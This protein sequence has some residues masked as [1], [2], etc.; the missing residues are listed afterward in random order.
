MCINGD[1]ITRYASGRQMCLNFSDFR[2]TSGLDETP[3]PR[4]SITRYALLNDDFFGVEL[5]G[6]ATGK[7]SYLLYQLGAFA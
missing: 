7:V 1:S 4:D 3:I 2:A 5:Q 6:D